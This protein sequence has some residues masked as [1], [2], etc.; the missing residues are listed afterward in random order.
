SGS[1]T[2]S[3]KAV[4]PDK[5]TRLSTNTSPLSNSKIL[6][7]VKSE[8]SE[9]NESLDSS[10]GTSEPEK[11]NL[12]GKTAPRISSPVSIESLNSSIIT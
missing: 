11:K 8:D 1:V 3:S 7:P 10:I 2:S 6:K 9:I 5:K 4:E 12:L